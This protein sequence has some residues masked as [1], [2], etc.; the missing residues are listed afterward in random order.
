MKRAVCFLTALALI[1]GISVAAQA[2][3][4]AAS[5]PRG[6]RGFKVLD[7]NGDG[8]VTKEEFLAASQKRAEARFAKLDKDNKGYLTKDDFTA[9]REK[10]REKAKTRKTKADV[11]Q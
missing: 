5:A 10:A 1:I 4:D 3:D 9:A 7:A 2:Q 8:K 6:E 11:P